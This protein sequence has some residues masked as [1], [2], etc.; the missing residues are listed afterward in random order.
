MEA[1]SLLPPQSHIYNE[2]LDTFG[3]LPQHFYCIV[4]T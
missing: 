3:I 1:I 2:F 4:V